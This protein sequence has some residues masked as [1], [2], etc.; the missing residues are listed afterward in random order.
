MRAEPGEG[1]FHGGC[2]AR[3]QTFAGSVDAPDPWFEEHLRSGSGLHP[4]AN[5]DA[6]HL[7][8]EF[9]YP[10]TVLP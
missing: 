9:P 10:L 2:R 8:G 7:A 3:A 1:G 6:C 4:G 5:V